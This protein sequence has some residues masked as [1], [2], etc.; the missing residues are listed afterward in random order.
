M[1]SLAPYLGH[2]YD[3][4]AGDIGV[5]NKLTVTCMMLIEN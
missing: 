3:V 2:D 4:P 1:E 5:S